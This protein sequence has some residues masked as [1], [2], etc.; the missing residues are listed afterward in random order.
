[1]QDYRKSGYRKRRVNHVDIWILHS[2]K[3]LA[4]YSIMS[5]YLGS[6]ARLE[7]KSMHTKGWIKDPV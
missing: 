7:N 4:A 1:M 6:V 5:N 3:M 2:Y